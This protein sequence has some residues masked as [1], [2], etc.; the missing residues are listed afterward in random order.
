M[1]VLFAFLD[2]FDFCIWKAFLVRELNKLSQE[3][4]DSLE[5]DASADVDSTTVSALRYFVRI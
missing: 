3:S 2:D 1:N 5:I 4:K